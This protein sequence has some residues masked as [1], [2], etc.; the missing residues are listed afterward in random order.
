MKVFPDIALNE[1]IHSRGLRTPW[2]NDKSK[3]RT[4][5]LT[6]QACFN[7]KLIWNP[8]SFRNKDLWS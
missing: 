7:F 6:A 3:T 2:K 4:F 5:L 8:I 1:P